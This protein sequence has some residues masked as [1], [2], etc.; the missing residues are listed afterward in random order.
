MNGDLNSIAVF[1]TAAESVSFAQAAEKLHVT[2]SA[3]ARTIARLEARL[4]ATLFQRTTRSQSLTDEG[5]LYYEYSRRALD[6]IGQAE[7][8]LESGKMQVNGTLRISMPVLFGQ[9]CVVPLLLALADE[10]PQLK[11]AL[12]FS[13]R[14]VDLTE[15]GFDMA[16]RIG[17]LEESGSLV[18]RRLASHGMVL[19][20]SPDYLQ[21]A[22]EPADVAQ[23]SQH[24]AVAYRQAG[25]TLLWRLKNE[26]QQVVEVLPPAR[27]VLDDMQAIKA[28][29]LRG[30][31]I[32][33]LPCWLVSEALADGTLRAI[34]PGRSCGDSPIYAV[35]PRMPYL[36]LKIRLAVDKL[37]QALPDAMRAVSSPEYQQRTAP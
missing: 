30:G 28:V 18:A 23:L 9:L 26:Q 19:C 1:V 5:A 29:V 24:A 7:A 4:G 33:W 21:R 13:D 37:V 16:V 8:M 35:W 22:G 6:E 20:A 31:G 32:A 3:V 12:S 14:Q 15:E 36:P 25:R 34:L 17:A 10:H 11:L 27:F 2:R